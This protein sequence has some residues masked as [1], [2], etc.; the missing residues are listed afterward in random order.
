MCWYALAYGF[1]LGFAV[2][3]LLT[4]AIRTHKSDSRWSDMDLRRWAVGH[5]VA[6]M[7]GEQE[8]YAGKV[9]H[10]ADEIYT[11]ALNKPPYIELE[12]QK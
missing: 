2:G 5:A 9:A 4:I 7:S 12:S 6:A 10:I 11:F 3:I 1:G 8:V